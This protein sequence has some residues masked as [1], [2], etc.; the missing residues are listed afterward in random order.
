MA[1]QNLIGMVVSQGKMQKTVKVRVESKL[2]N[3]KI[4]K[5]LFHRKDYLVHDEGEVSREGDLVRIEATRPIS[6]RKFFSIAEILRN[7]GQQFAQYQYQVKSDVAK[8]EALKTQQFLERRS[9]T[10]AQDNSILL[11]DVRMIQNALSKGQSVEE[12]EEIKKRYGITEF[13][14]DTLK[15]ILKLNVSDLQEKLTQQRSKID[16]LHEKLDEFMN[17]DNKAIDYLKKHGIEDP[18]LLQKNIKRNILRKHL[19]QEL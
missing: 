8:E 10:E 12:L 18:T 11:K 14:Q 17:D 7:K 5:E 4:N 6:K 15:E 2:F 3:K 19:L 1:R 13:S 9:H 16:S